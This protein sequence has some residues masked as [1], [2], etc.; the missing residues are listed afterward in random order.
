MVFSCQIYFSSH[1]SGLV[2]PILTEVHQRLTIVIQKAKEFF[3]HKCPP[4]PFPPS[5]LGNGVEK[6]AF[7]HHVVDVFSLALA[8]TDFR[9]VT[10]HGTIG[11]FV[12][13][14]FHGVTSTRCTPL[15][16]YT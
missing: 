12:G 9:T 16:M 7:S 5:L 13:G 3:I 14:G 11:Y 6:F 2:S 8:T 1:N 10:Y 15:S 4:P